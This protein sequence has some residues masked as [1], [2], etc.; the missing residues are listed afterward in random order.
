SSGDKTL[1]GLINDILDLSRIEAGKMELQYEVANP[2]FILNE[3]KHIFSNKAK[4]KNLDFIVEAAPDLP[5]VL[6]LD[7]LRV[8]QVLFNLVGNAL[9]FTHRGYI[10]LSAHADTGERGTRLVF[11]VQDSGI[12]I[13]QHQQQ[14]IFEAFKQ[15]EGQ[16]AVKYGGTGLGLTI[17]RRLVE[18]MGGEISVRSE[19]G[20]G[21]TFRV[22][23]KDITVPEVPRGQEMDIKPDVEDVRFEK[24]LILAADR[25]E[26]NRRLLAEYLAG[27]PIDLIEAQDGREAVDMVRKY[28]PDLVLMDKKMPVMGGCEAVKILKAD[29]KLKNIPVIIVTASALTEEWPEIEQAGADGHLNKPLSKSDLIIELMHH[30][31]YSIRPDGRSTETAEQKNGSPTPLS[32]ENRAKIPELLA[33]LQSNDLNHRL[34]TLNKTLILDE[35]EEFSKEIKELG[36]VYHA[37]VLTNWADRLYDDSQTYDPGK[38]HATL[39]AFPGIIKEIE[40]LSGGQIT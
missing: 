22:T 7:T 3:I 13:P 15:R 31:P 23:L 28:R 30:F 4:E 35:I 8:R 24:A 6:F 38:M 39:A 29:E 1:L 32:P 16:L 36:L 14:I 37:G 26:Y 17:C 40:N 11:S 18:M 21:S 9:K 12:G 2:R 27:S 25:E 34:Q 19:E 33:I 5:E 10:K 20:K